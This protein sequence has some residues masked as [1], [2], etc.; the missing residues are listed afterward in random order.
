MVALAVLTGRGSCCELAVE[1]TLRHAQIALLA[2]LLAALLTPASSALPADRAGPETNSYLTVSDGKLVYEGQDVVL[3][4]ENFNNEPALSCCG[5]PD[6]DLIN[7]NIADYEQASGVLGENVIRF[8]L[9]YAWYA[10]GRA[11]FF[12]VVDRQVAWAMAN[13]VWLIPVMYEPPGGT[14]GGYGGQ[15]G[16]WNSAPNQQALIDF[17]ADFASHYQGNSTIAGYDVFNEPAPPSVATYDSW[18][19]RVYDAITAADPNH[20]V[21]LEVSSADW[22]LP[23]VNGDRILWSGHCY[24]PVGAEGCSFPGADP[25]NPTKRPFLVGEVGARQ[26]QGTAYVPDDLANFNQLGVSWVHFVMH[27]S[28]FGLYQNWDA[29]NFSAPWTEMIQAVVAA[30]AG[31]IK[32]DCGM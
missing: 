12:A 28:G 22:D 23:S 18:A 19:Q 16:F 2:T 13:H 32:P 29:G 11:M 6:I 7:S 10:A 5:G 15:D 3:R 8:G 25:S 31:T 17:W 14:D 27:E 1:P 30:T 26:S 9:D 24:A 4:G 20:F 21:V